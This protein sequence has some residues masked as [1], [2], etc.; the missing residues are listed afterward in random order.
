MPSADAILFGTTTTE[1]EETIPDDVFSRLVLEALYANRQLTGVVAA[2]SEDLTARPGDTVKVISMPTR[3]AQGPVAEGAALADTADDPTSVAIGLDKFGDLNVLTREVLEDAD[4]LDRQDYVRNMSEALAE[5]VDQEAYDALETATPGSTTTL[6]NAGDLSDLYTKI[7][8]LK[9]AMKGAKVAPDTVILHP[10][11]EA[12]FLKDTNE[13]VTFQN[14]RAQDGELTGVAGLNPIVSP[15]ANPN[16]STLGEVQAVV[17]DSSRALGEA[18]GRR[19]D[20]IVDEQT[21]ADSDE[22]RLIIWIRYGSAALDATAVG[23][24]VNP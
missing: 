9:A 2:V 18:W 3:A 11:H 7:V 12:Q 4:V 20:I 8:D 17:A 22:I 15:L 6:A 14:I 23:H 5:K 16:T 13:G 24:V 19:P 10:D 21:L 1:A